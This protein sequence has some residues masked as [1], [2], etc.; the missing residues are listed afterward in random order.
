MLLVSIKPPERQI[1]RNN[2]DRREG[3]EITVAAGRSSAPLPPLAILS[4][5]APWL[6]HP[7]LDLTGPAWIKETATEGLNGGA[8]RPTEHPVNVNNATKSGANNQ[9]P[10]QTATEAHRIYPDGGRSVT[11]SIFDP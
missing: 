8:A 10:H 5:R 9:N 3:G 6:F 1:K 11:I 7:I 2:G 4:T